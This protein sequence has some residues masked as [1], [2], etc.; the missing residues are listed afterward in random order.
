MARVGVLN[1]QLKKEA[2]GDSAWNRN[3]FEHNP[4]AIAKRAYEKFLA[5]GRTHGRDWQD[6]FEAETELKRTT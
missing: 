3:R 4:E 1:R 5:R 6:W 2:S